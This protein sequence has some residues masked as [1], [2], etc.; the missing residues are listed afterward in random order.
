TSVAVGADAAIYAAWRHVYPGNIRDIAFT[1]SHDG[2]RS[3]AAPI[4][5]S[6]DQWALDGC[7][8]NGPALAI[9]S[10]ERVHIAW[11][12]LVK[13]TA[14]GSAPNLALFYAFRS[15]DR[16]SPRQIIPTSGPPRHPSPAAGPMGL[17]LL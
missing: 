3:F 11:P 13:S 15:G 7:P 10:R 12:T 14:A 17:L 8:E 6:D 1:W 2:G 4:R 16:F 5:V 9:D